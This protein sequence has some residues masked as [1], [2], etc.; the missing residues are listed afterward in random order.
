MA[1]DWETARADGRIQQGIDALDREI[2]SPGCSGVAAASITGPGA[3]DPVPAVASQP[4]PPQSQPQPQAA[5]S[6]NAMPEHCVRMNLTA[7]Q[8]EILGRVHRD[9][10]PEIFQDP[11]GG[12]MPASQS[13][14]AQQS[15]ASQ[16]SSSPQRSADPPRSSTTQVT[17]SVRT[18]T[19]ITGVTL[20]S[21]QSLDI[22]ATGSAQYA[23]NC[24]AVG[25]NG[26]SRTVG[27]PCAWITSRDASAALLSSVGPGTLLVRVG[28]GPWQAVAAGPTTVRGSGAVTLGF[29][30]CSPIA[31]CYSDNSGSYQVTLTVT[32]R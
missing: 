16:Q 15:P 19:S 20:S 3:S 1:E 28:D 21:S 27:A 30:D 22:S 31:T 9:D 7:E 26:G 12:S 10:G 25:P 24:P 14:P 8:C 23:P 29:N 32:S 18:P 4:S 2:G 5:P 17:V 11:S 13:P 6:T